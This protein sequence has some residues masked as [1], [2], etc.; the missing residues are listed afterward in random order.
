MMIPSMSVFPLTSV[1][2]KTTRV[3]PRGNSDPLGWLDVIVTSEQMSVAVGSSQ[4]ATAVQVR[5]SAAKSGTIGN[6]DS[7]GGIFSVTV[8]VKLA[9]DWLP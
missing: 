8:T 3:S 7:T 4:V 2:V 5:G 9:V 1:A 6:C